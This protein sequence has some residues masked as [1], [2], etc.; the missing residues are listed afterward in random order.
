MA[1]VGDG[2]RARFHGGAGGDDVVHQQD[3]S[4][5]QPFGVGHAEN[6]PYVFLPL[7]FVQAGLA[8]G[9]NGAH[10]ALRVDGQSGGL[11]YA[12]CYPGTLVVAPLAFLFPREGDGDD[13]VHAFEKAL[14]LEGFA[15]HAAHGFPHFR[16]VVVFQGEKDAAVGRVAGV[17]EERRGPLHVD[18]P[19]EDAG[20]VVVFPREE[21]HARQAFEAT[22]AERFLQ[23]REAAAATDAIA[24]EYEVQQAAP[25]EGKV[26]QNL[27]R[28]HAGSA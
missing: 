18:Q 4:A 8:G 1:D 26:M 24:R 15:H 22:G 21:A 6:V 7:V 28:R 25:E 17:V 16:A 5:L 2:L 11:G 10:H 9:G 13:E 3:V 12:P 19:P 20:D 27:R 14:A 23:E